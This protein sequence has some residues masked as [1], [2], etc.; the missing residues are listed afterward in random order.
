MGLGRRVVVVLVLAL[1]GFDEW[2]MVEVGKPVPL[3][4]ALR[5]YVGALQEWMRYRKSV[6]GSTL[7]CGI[8]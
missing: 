8:S 5:L 3:L 1:L 2:I 4:D 7:V 6:I